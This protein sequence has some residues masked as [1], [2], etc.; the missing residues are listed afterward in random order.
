MRALTGLYADENLANEILSICDVVLV[1]V[2]TSP[3]LDQLRQDVGT[4]CERLADATNRYSCRD[5]T[6]IAAARVQVIVALEK[7]QDAALERLIGSP[8]SSSHGALRPQP[9]SGT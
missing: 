6:V 1:G 5:P 2:G 8:P 9:L 4:C 7:I 3:D